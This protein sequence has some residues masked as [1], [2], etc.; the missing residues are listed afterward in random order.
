[1][2]TEIYLYDIH[3]RVTSKHMFLKENVLANLKIK[4]F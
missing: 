1:M 4:L 3:E 2:W